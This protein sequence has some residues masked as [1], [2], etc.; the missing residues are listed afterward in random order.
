[1]YTSATHAGLV[2]DIAVLVKMG[3]LMAVFSRL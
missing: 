3:A 1:M 2:H